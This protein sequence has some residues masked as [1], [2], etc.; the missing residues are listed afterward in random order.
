MKDQEKEVQ[1][2][3]KCREQSAHKAGYEQA[4]KEIRE[5]WRC[6]RCKYCDLMTGEITKNTV[7]YGCL[8]SEDVCFGSYT[9]PDFGCIH[10][11]PKEQ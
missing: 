9:I 10:F 11:E 3:I 7:I 5:Q 6:E 4:L 1:Q 2:Y 8:K